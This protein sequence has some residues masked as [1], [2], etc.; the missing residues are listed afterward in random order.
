[1][2]EEK[3]KSIVILVYL[4]RRCRHDLVWDDDQRLFLPTLGKG[5]SKG[6]RVHKEM[7]ERHLTPK[8]RQKCRHDLI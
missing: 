5:R 7:S 2:V 8:R 4:S 1:M 3:S 6:L